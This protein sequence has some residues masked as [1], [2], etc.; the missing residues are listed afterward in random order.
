[1]SEIS[2]GSSFFYSFNKKRQKKANFGGFGKLRI[3]TVKKTLFL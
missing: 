2:I 1:M 3:K